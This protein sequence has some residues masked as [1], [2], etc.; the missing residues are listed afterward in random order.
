VVVALGEPG[1]PVMVCAEA[2]WAMNITA[3]AVNNDQL[4]EVEL[5]LDFMIYS[6]PS[7]WFLLD[8]VFDDACLSGTGPIYFCQPV[9]ADTTRRHD[10]KNKARKDARRFQLSQ[11]NQT[12]GC[13]TCKAFNDDNGRPIERRGAVDEFDHFICPACRSGYF[14][15]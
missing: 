12:I 13:G 10:R 15:S 11:G 7:N 2:G 4:K 8:D 9:Y 6:L 14:M 1:V 5:I 3:T